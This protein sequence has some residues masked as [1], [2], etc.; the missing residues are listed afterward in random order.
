MR[1][2]LQCHCL[3]AADKDGVESLWLLYRQPHMPRS[4]SHIIIAVIYH[5]PDAV[6]LITTT[7][8]VDNVDALLRQHPHS[9]VIL[10]GDFNRMPDAPLRDIPLKQIVKA[11]TRKQATLDKIY[12]NIPEWYHDPTILPGIGQSDH[13][14]IAMLPIGSVFRKKGKRVAI[15][16]RSN[17]SN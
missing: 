3:N 8:I 12:T 11:A 1:N 4:V 14:A 6:N 17:D 2:K 16:V 13:H 9:G 10:V 7:H 5:P 15:T